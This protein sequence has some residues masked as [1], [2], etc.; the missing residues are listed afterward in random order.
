[1]DGWRDRRL[2]KCRELE[3]FVYE[4]GGGGVSLELWKSVLY[5]Y[6]HTYIIDTHPFG[7]KVPQDLAQQLYSRTIRGVN[8]LL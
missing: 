4:R 2:G 5:I 8:F 7:G 6:T 3:G 1:M